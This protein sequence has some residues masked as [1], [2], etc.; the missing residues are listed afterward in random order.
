VLLSMLL[1]SISASFVIGYPL[2]RGLEEVSQ[3]RHRSHVLADRLRHSSDDLTRM[4]RTY[5]A[6]GQRFYRD[7]FY[8]VLAIRNGERPRP[9]NYDRVYWDLILSPA[10]AAKLPEMGPK[11]PLKQL[12]IEAGIEA[13][14]LALLNKAEARSNALVLLEQQAMHAMEGR[15]KGPDGR[16]TV[17]RE[18]DPQLAMKLLHGREYHQAKKA[19]MEPIGQFM[20]LLD[21]RTRQ[22]VANEVAR[23]RWLI[24]AL[25]LQLL[26][27]AAAVAYVLIAINRQNRAHLALLSEEVRRKTHDLATANQELRRSNRDLEQFAYVASHDLQEP[28]RMVTSYLQLLE[29]RLDDKLDDKTGTYFNYVLD[30]ASRMKGLIDALLRFSRAG[31]S[32]SPLET[33]PSRRALDSALEALEVVIKESGA[34]VVA[35]PLPDVHWDEA[36]LTQVFQNL[37][38]NAI[39]FRGEAPPRVEVSGGE[40][41]GKLVLAVKD[42][43]I[44]IDAAHQERIFQVFQRL[45]G[46]QQ[47]EGTGIGLALVQRIVERRGGEIWVESASGEGSTFS[48][49]VPRE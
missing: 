6:T 19:I 39:K 24:L 27:A 36:Q 26:T 16:Y 12:M 23:I 30:G 9:R 20:A 1:V 43:G 22:Q 40:K 47:Y 3:N 38:G 8:E 18:P 7:Q 4:V 21:A 41:D 37:V 35:G 32:E 48:F 34:E 31:D 2:M 15:F 14:E 33:F 13:K 5:A 44:G 46:Q 29:R 11:K 10:D 25:I 17:Q 49:T 42:N 28:L 45:H